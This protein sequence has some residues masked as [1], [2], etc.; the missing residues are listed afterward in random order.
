MACMS[1]MAT[2]KVET[3]CVS[4]SVCDKFLE[5]S[6]DLPIGILITLLNLPEIVNI[7]KIKR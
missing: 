2:L 5:R 6:I 1:N 7:L 4:D 3:I